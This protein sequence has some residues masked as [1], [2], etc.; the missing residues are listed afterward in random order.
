MAFSSSL[1]GTARVVLGVDTRDFNRDLSTAENRFRTST[2]NMDRDVGQLSRGVAAGTGAFQGFARSIAFASAS[3]LGAAGLTS[4]VKQSVTAASDLDEAVNAATATFK[5]SAPQVKA[6]A[7]T[8]ADA[9]GQSER[10]ALRNATSIGAMLAPMGFARQAAADMSM[11]MVQLAS[12]MASFSNEDP[13]EMLDRIRSGLAGESEPLRRFGVDLRETAVQAFALREGL[14]KKGEALSAAGQLVARYRLILEQ[15]KDQQGDFARTAD[16]AANQ[17]RKLAANIEEAQAALGRA[18]LPTLERLLPKLSEWADELAENEELHDRIADAVEKAA[19]FVGD[20]ATAADDA[21]KKVGGWDDALAL[22]ATGGIAKALTGLVGASTFAGGAVAARGGLLGALTRLAGIGTIPLMIELEIG[23]RTGAAGRATGFLEELYKLANGDIENIDWET[24]IGQPR[25]LG[26]NVPAL[27]GLNT[28][29]A[30][31]TF[32]FSSWSGIRRGGG[33]K[34]HG[35]RAVGNWYSDNAIDLMGPAWA[36]VY[37]VEDGL[38]GAVTLRPTNGR[39]VS[40]GSTVFL[41]GDSGTSYAY[42]HLEGSTVTVRQGMRVKAGSFIGRIGPK[43]AG[44]PHLHLGVSRGDPAAVFNFPVGKVSSGSSSQTGRGRQDEAAVRSPL[45]GRAPLPD[46]TGGRDDKTR[47]PPP[48]I[49]LVLQERLLR[50]QETK[51]I[52]DDLAVLQDIDR[53]LTRKIAAEKNIEKRVALRRERAGIRTDIEHLTRQPKSRGGT[54]DPI[55]AGLY[56]REARAA[57]TKPLRD[58]LDALAAIDAYLTKRI[59]AEKDVK[60][61]TALI[62]ERQGVRGRIADVQEQLPVK[63]PGFTKAPAPL[64][65]FGATMG[66]FERLRGGQQTVTLPGL[67]QVLV[68][69]MSASRAMWV[70]MI[71]QLKLK[72]R[73]AIQRRKA[74]ERSQQRAK[75]LTLKRARD[76]ALAEIVPNLRKARQQEQEL[77]DA[78]GTALTAVSEIDET[79]ASEAQRAANEA[80][81]NR[82]REAEEELRE[83]ERAEAAFQRSLLDTPVD[84][85]YA[86]ALAGGTADVGDDIAALRREESFL[87]GNLGR[88][89]LETEVQLINSLNS[90]REQ[91]RRLEE[92]QRQ[93]TGATLTLVDLERERLGFLTSLRQLRQYQ[94]NLWDPLASLHGSTIVVHNHYKTMPEDPLLYSR[95]IE[96]ELRAMVG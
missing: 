21:A 7:E 33:A 5:E 94:G 90:V 15:T 2:R 58:D 14:I 4:V 83:S 45:R 93:S 89:T 79:A 38:I 76:L 81:Q 30:A 56:L 29:G 54:D 18:F 71:S 74:L 95:E 66:S 31:R 27:R 91:I 12:D 78:L 17:Q 86:K 44:G 84:I 70:Q 73:A 32:P 3:F 8:A 57:D 65:G 34:E 26:K 47:T 59:A 9:F 68:G 92:A 72:L 41:H 60:E 24:L 80:E 40:D 20:F 1:A 28:A 88:G 52:A 37:A 39:G 61:K 46:L 62:R 35:S 11:E 6:W 19:D 96:F 55:L 23:R 10:A 85:L 16:T 13:T 51:K 22:L 77:R 36:A 43:T 67:G 63:L 25:G 48:S 50:A 64:A 82:L 69:N 75:S 42:M 53:L 49:P 87:A